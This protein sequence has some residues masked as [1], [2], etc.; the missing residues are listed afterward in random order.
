[1][2]WATRVTGPT[3]LNPLSAINYNGGVVI[4]GQASDG[5]GADGFVVALDSAGQ[6]VFGH[7]YGRTTITGSAPLIERFRAVSPGAGGTLLLAGDANLTSTSLDGWIA[8]IGASDGKLIAS[9]TGTNEF[10]IGSVTAA[11]SFYAV[12]QPTTG[13]FFLTGETSA[14]AV[15]NPAAMW[16][17]R[18]ADDFQIKF[19]LTEMSDARTGSTLLKDIAAD[20]VATSCVGVNPLRVVTAT[21]RGIEHPSYDPQPISFTP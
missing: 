16:G 9:S 19:R 18:V 20:P 13:G 1:V 3:S 5:R 11:D 7:T 14:S 21:T 10:A 6:P 2:Q 17:L 12:T 8:Q 15:P 4:A